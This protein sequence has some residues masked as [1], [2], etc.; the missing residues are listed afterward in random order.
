MA[1]EPMITA[2]PVPQ[3]VLLHRRDSSSSG[4]SGTLDT[5]GYL[6]GDY[7]MIP[8]T[9][10]VPP[11]LFLLVRPASQ[12]TLLATDEPLSDKPIL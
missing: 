3:E 9:R 6:S 10:S 1:M 4:S 7:G 8:R 2:A 11:S 12:L 5:C